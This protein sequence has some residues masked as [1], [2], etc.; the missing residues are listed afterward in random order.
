MKVLPLK[1]V[2]EVGMRGKLIVIEGVDGSGKQTQSEKLYRTLES[3]GLKV[4]KIE[5][6]DYDSE[7]S[8]LVK[9]YLRG[10]F[11]TNPEDVSAYVA[12]SFF[13]ADRYASYNTK[14]KEFYL[15]GGIII[16]DRYTTANMVHQASK[17][18]DKIERDKFLEWLYDLEFNIYEIPKPDLVFFLDVPPIISMDITKERRNKI[19]GETKK[20]IHERDTHHLVASYKN[21]HYVADKYGW[22]KINC[23]R[24]EKMKSKEEIFNDIYLATIEKL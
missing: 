18:G 14:W 10:D 11:G 3:K 8:A 5:F 4:K 17:I 13:A 12:S 1:K 6:P 24:E 7:S 23:V 21:A 15:S 20:D 9:M 19:T 2:C 22:Q 16:A